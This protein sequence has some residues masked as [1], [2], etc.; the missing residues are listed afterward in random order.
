MRALAALTAVPNAYL[1]GLLAAAFAVR[2]GSP[3]EHDGRLPRVAVVVPAHDEEAGIATTVASLAAAGSDLTIVVA[4]NCTDATAERARAAGATVWE[5]MDPDL[6][7]KGHALAWAF[8]R[9]PQDVEAVAV[10]DA[11]C[12]VST[13]FVDAVATRLAAGARAVQASYLVSNPEQSHAA[14]ARYAGYA[15]VNHVRPLGK[16]ALGLSCGLF[17]SGMAF[18]AALLREHP[19]S[20]FAVT[21]DAEYHLQLVEAGL[22]VEFAPEA[23]VESAMPTSLDVA[24]TQ[25][26]RWESGRFDLARGRALRLVAMG[27]QRHDPA[28]LN[29]GLELLMPPQSLLLAANLA[30]ARRPGL[31]A[32]AV[33]VLG[34]LAVVGAPAAVY[35]SLA[36]APLLVARNARLYARLAGGWRP[37]GW[38]RTKR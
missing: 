15:L 3:P 22:R 33:Y 14:A 38:V 8:E 24:G 1:L 11:D 18:D 28:R 10:V 16:S 34:G 4:D 37:R 13:N 9:V 23:S 35:R 27:V 25:R 26:E 7:G 36:M 29:A 6:L 30:F 12:T 17:G 20:A 31:A 2:R 21:E 32:Q 19:W 5:R